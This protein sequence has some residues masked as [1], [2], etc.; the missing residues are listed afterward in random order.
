[1]KPVVALNNTFPSTCCPMRNVHDCIVP[2]ESEVDASK[3][4]PK[5][6]V[7]IAHKVFFFGFMLVNISIYL[8]CH[9]PGSWKKDKKFKLRVFAKRDIILKLPLSGKFAYR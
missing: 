4:S 9:L 1:M 6:N 2:G 3:C 8:W 7:D 5:S